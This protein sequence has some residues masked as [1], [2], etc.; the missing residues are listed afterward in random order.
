MQMVDFSHGE[1]W[2][3]RSHRRSTSAV[4][5][6]AC[7]P[8]GPRPW[9]PTIRLRWPRQLS[10]PR[11]SRDKAPIAGSCTVSV[12]RQTPHEQCPSTGTAVQ[13]HEDGYKCFLG[14]HPHESDLLYQ[15]WDTVH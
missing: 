9:C 2:Q 7:P 15:Y 3:R 5:K 12:D 4:G 1:R 14:D 13:I 8:C 11:E 6:P 10:A